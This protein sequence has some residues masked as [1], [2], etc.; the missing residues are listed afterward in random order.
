MHKGLV[1]G[2][3]V[4]AAPSPLRSRNT[5]EC[6]VKIKIVRFYNN[7]VNEELNGKFDYTP[8]HVPDVGLNCAQ[9]SFRTGQF[10]S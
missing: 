8:E 7:L 9:G 3:A 10:N 5:K 6:V 4:V 1:T 2:V